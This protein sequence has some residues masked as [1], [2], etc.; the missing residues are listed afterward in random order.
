MPTNT[1]HTPQPQGSAPRP[2]NVAPSLSICSGCGK[3]CGMPQHSL[4]KAQLYIYLFFLRDTYTQVEKGKFV[5][6]KSLDDLILLAGGRVVTLR[7][8]E[9]SSSD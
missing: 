5:Q 9:R 8:P 2:W 7:S 3:A 1:E 4:S 6:V